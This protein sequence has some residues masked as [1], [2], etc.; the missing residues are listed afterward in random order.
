MN[1][2][3]IVSDINR[4]KEI[5]RLLES[6][7]VAK[8]NEMLSLIAK[9]LSASTSL[10]IEANRKDIENGE[11]QNLS[12]VLIKRLV[13]DKKK[14]ESVIKGINE[15]IAL[16]DP[17]S[18]VR[19]RRLLDEGLI[20]EQI[21][22]S[23]GV[24]GMIF[25]SRPDALVQIISLALKSGNAIVLKGGKEAL[26]T[27]TALVDI[28]KQALDVTSIGGDWIV[29]LTSREDVSLILNL[30]ESIDL[31]IPRGSNEFVQYI[32]KNSSIPVLGHSDGLCSMYIDNEIDID[33]ALKVAIDSKC[34]YPSVCNSIETLLVHSDIAHQ[35]IPLFKTLS[36][37]YNVIIHGDDTTCNLIEAI[38]ATDADWDTE[39]LD[40]EIAI[41][42]V[43][44]MDEA[45]NHIALHG[46]K[47]TDCIVT[48]NNEKAKRFLRM[49]DSA[50]VFHNCSTRFSD[51]NRFGL[52]AEV[53]IST[54][55]IHARGPV[56]LEGLVTT[57]WLLQG[58]GHIVADYEKDASFKHE[59]M[60][61]DGPSMIEVDK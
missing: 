17:L 53:G 58:N 11:K 32:M 3:R 24:I 59:T 1:K 41:K 34:Q 9:A 30:H 31:L 50:D 15:V 44:S 38:E 46:S 52:G 49:V 42:V 6:S 22:V 45:M 7:P 23:I 51:G 40:Y 8:R 14:I 29:H 35:F 28:I 25:E 37:S 2:K 36:E 33:L 20:L 19:V 61:S 54:Q 47:H 5:Q 57:K 16:E 13:F 18:G 4:A 60:T 43:S 12:K 10:I 21:P 48:T 27:N 26:H 56:G 55:K 39:Y